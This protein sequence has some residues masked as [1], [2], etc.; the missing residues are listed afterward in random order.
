EKTPVKSLAFPARVIVPPDAR[1]IFPPLVRPLPFVMR[2]NPTPLAWRLRP[3]STTR[4]RPS[5]IPPFERSI[6]TRPVIEIS[7]PARKVTFPLE[8]LA[9]AM[10]VPPLHDRFLV[11]S[12]DSVTADR[13]T[14]VVAP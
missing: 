9:A 3:A 1:V 2:K 5:V 8:L 6:S 10:R 7:F 13:F 14:G 4:F 11:A 12:N